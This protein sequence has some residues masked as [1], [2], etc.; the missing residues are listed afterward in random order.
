MSNVDLL[1][2]SVLA[3]MGDAYWSLIV[4]E[5]LIDKGFTKAKDLQKESVKYVSAKAQARFI[6]EFEDMFDAKDLEI[7]KRGRNYKS[8]SVPKNTDVSTYRISTGFEAVVGYWYLTKQ[9]TKLTVLW[10]KV[11]T[12][13]EE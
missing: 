2:G 3:Y 13:M 4:R 5:Y 9:E 10:N 12:L 1:N 6:H 8:T 7:F 11:K